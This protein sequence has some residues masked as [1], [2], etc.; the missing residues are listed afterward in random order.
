MGI[1]DATIARSTRAFIEENPADF[2]FVRPRW[3]ST[4]AGGLKKVEPPLTLAPQRGR[5]VES[6]LASASSVRTLPDG[7][8]VNV[9]ATIVLMP[10]A[11][12]QDW[13]EVEYGGRRYMV[14]GTS[15]RWAVNAEVSRYAAPK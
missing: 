7:R 1:G 5:F 10:G 15:G 2:E 9:E 14:I 11:D 4:P 3:E 12:V 8:V 13:D 6:N